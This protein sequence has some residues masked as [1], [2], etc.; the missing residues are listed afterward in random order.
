MTTD[1]VNTDPRHDIR[2][3]VQSY[4][5]SEQSNPDDNHYVFAY[6]VNIHNN[7]SVPAKLLSRH[8]IITDSDGKTQEV[9]GEGVIGEQPHIQPG[10]SFEYTSGTH[11]ETPVGSMHG[12]YQMMADDGVNFDAEIPAFTLAL[13]S[14]LH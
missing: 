13:P 14:A 12:S 10:D 4:Y 6:T 1:P 3:S 5:I 8:W 9:T 2:V 7:G 11:M